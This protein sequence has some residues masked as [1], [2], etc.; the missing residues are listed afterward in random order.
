MFAILALIAFVIALIERNLGPV[1]MAV[2]GLCFLA[3]HLV[4]PIGLGTVVNRRVQ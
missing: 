1:D 4:W 2:L 3:L